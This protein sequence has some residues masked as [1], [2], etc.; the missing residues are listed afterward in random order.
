MSYP[1]KPKTVLERLK[2]AAD[3]AFLIIFIG[4]GL[5]ILYAYKT[6]GADIKG[7]AFGFFSGIAV[8][9]GGIVAYL[10]ITLAAKQK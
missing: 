4:G 3:V 7:I 9:G 10:L 5:G 1:D 6:G 8:S 2:A